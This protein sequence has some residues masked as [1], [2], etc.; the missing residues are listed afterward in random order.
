LTSLRRGVLL[1]VPVGLLLGAGARAHGQASG[2]IS[3]QIAAQISGQ[4]SGSDDLDDPK[5]ARRLKT[6]VTIPSRATPDPA[7]GRPAPLVPLDTLAVTPSLP[8]VTSSAVAPRTPSL[9]APRSSAAPG[10]VAVVEEPGRVQGP[11]QG[12]DK[13]AILQIAY[14]RFSFVQIGAID[15]GASNGKSAAE[16]FD[17]LSLDFYPISRTIRFGI[18]TQYGWQSGT[19][20]SG[21]GDYLIAETFSLG[22]QRPG[23]T[24]TPFVQA[25]GGAGYMRRFQFDRTVPTAYWQFGVDAGTEIALA[26][27]AFLTAAIGYLHPVNGFFKEQSFATV[28]VDTWSFK[29]AIGI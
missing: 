10:P 13:T 15:P 20:N 4:S 16:A 3:G 7:P 23:P 17:S 2:Q 29:I 25:L 24:L 8:P 1:V 12:D 9:A 22:I 21:T 5:L 11:G 18:S 26:R 28:Y 6:R 27:H 19:F 14:R